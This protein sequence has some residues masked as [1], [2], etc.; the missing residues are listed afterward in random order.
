M[1]HFVRFG[2]EYPDVVRDRETLYAA[3]SPP[4]EVCD[5]EGVTHYFN[6]ASMRRFVLIDT[7]ADK[8]TAEI[9]SNSEK[10]DNACGG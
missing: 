5:F 10:A 8:R 3:I 2:I 1:V 6:A 9:L 7:L 4:K